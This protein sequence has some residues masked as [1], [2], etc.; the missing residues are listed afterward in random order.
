MNVLPINILIFF[1]KEL[2]FSLLKKSLK[3]D[4]DIISYDKIYKVMK[5]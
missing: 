5:Y 1:K 2:L 3:N 4:I